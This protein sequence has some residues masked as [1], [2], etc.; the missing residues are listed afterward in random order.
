MRGE[1]KLERQL[2]VLE[3]DLRSH[4]LRVLPGVADSGSPLFTNSEFNPMISI[5][6]SFARIQTPNI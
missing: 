3:Q 6:R 5:L 1:Q 4:L 2:Q